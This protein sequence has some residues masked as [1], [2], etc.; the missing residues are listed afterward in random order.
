MSAA[1]NSN[2]GQIQQILDEI[3]RSK[4]AHTNLFDISIPTPA[5]GNLGSLLKFRGK[6]TQLPSSE[7]G[8]IEVPYRGRRLKVPGQRTFS[9]WSVTIME[10]E[11]MEVRSALETWMES[12]DGAA[13]AQRDASKIT[14]GSVAV[15]KS[16]GIT[17]SIKFL[18]WGLFPTSISNVELSF[19]EQTAPLEY[20]VTFQYSY[21]TIESASKSNQS[22]T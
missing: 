5:P 12:L 4:L 2:S 15:L 16:N 14:N 1:P 17:P 8:T 18:L 3:K 6:G 21:H 13:T 20:S 11:G 19:D 9:E 7:L 22:S 10:T